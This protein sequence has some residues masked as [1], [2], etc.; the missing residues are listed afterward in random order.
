MGFDSDR[1]QMQHL[2]KC[3]NIRPFP[4]N[5][6]DYQKFVGQ[7]KLS[8]VLVAVFVVVVSYFSFHNDDFWNF[9]FL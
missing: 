8:F 4:D 3:P 7:A 6:K 1:L 9:S 2:W 5:G